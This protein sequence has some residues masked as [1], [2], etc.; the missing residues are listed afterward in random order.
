MVEIIRRESRGWPE[1][2]NPKSTASG[3][4]QFLDGTFQQECVDKY[5]MATS[6]DQKNNPFLQ[7]QC[8]T[9][10]LEQPEGWKHWSASLI[11]NGN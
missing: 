5:K 7:I 9:K 4:F 10:M 6:T 2:K 3:L 8:A 11:P 1:A